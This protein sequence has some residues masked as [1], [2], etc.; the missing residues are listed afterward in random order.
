MSK[1]KQKDL[2]RQIEQLMDENAH[3]PKQ[4]TPEWLVEK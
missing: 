3:R 1:D 4:C 2:T